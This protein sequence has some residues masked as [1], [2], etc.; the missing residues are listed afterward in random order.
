MELNMS[1][2]N[3]VW[4]AVA[5][6]V[7]ILLVVVLVAVSKAKNRRRQQRAEE[8]REQA[9]VET[10][11]VERREALATE[12]AARARAAQAEAEAKAAEAA[13]LQDR[14]ASHQSEAATSREQLQDQWKHA[15]SLD[16]N[17]KAETSASE[18]APDR[19]WSG[20]QGTDAGLSGHGRS[21]NPRDAGGYPT[22]S[23]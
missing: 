4:I 18:D 9:R 3:V 1:T 23:G 11:K 22:T 15:D 14:A 16:P 13:R 12:T 19:A 21:A 10:A 2:S 7:A 20:E 5:A 17:T 8:I 6:I